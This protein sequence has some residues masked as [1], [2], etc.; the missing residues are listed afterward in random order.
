[1]SEP[2]WFD[3]PE[4]VNKLWYGLLIACG[5]LVVVGLFTKGSA[6]YAIER[7]PGM[8]EILSFAGFVVVVLAAR[9]L[10]TFVM[11][12]EDYYDRD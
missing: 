7:I 12:D 2:G 5:A 1:M 10:R 11:R 4:N 9:A 8:L 6:H 3:R